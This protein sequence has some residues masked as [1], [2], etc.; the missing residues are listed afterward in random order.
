MTS[1]RRFAFASIFLLALAPG[2]ALA[3]R[4][5]ADLETARQLYNQGIE[6]R[7]KGDLAGALE[8][9]KS[10]HA[11][12]NTPIT[13]AELCKTHAALKQPVEAREVCL[14]VGR[15]P[16]LSGETERSQ[17]ARADA[18]RVAEEV[19]GRMGSVTV[20]LQGV[21]PG[22]EPTV[23]I[24]GR[25]L[26]PEALDVARAVN[27]GKHVVTARVGSGGETRATLEVRE[28]ES[29][30]LEL[31]V[32]P[33]PA[34]EPPVAA[35]GAAPTYYEPPP[36]KAKSSVLPTVG[37]V[38]AGVGAA[39]GTAGGL[40]ALSAKGDL[41]DACLP[42]PDGTKTCGRA[43]HATLSRGQTWGT[44][45]TVAFVGAGVGV[46]LAVIGTLSNRSSAAGGAASKPAVATPRVTPVLGLGAGGIHGTF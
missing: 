45:S 14:S 39:I 9:L 18:A 33:P 8:K 10:A 22:R 28:G 12:G 21:P 36:K 3:Q 31:T 2:A 42:A 20:K 35:G 34:D 24:D 29:R 40:V 26:P 5:A 16:P 15:I 37:W 7:D 11:L 4:T 38:M 30:V 6:L 46:V 23:T 32:Q 13:G 43:D 44:V 25:A 17:Q 41:D 19:K 1:S 27:P